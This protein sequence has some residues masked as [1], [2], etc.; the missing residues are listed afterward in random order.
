MTARVTSCRME[1]ANVGTLKL[2]LSSLIFCSRQPFLKITLSSRARLSGLSLALDTLFSAPSRP[3]M[4]YS[5]PQERTQP[6]SSSSSSAVSISLSPS[7]MT[8][9]LITSASSNIS[10]TQPSAHHTAA[11]TR[12]ARGLI[13]KMAAG[14]RGI[15][16]APQT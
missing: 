2:Y 10:L 1:M 12:T 3:L 15:F 11:A 4:S 6:L 8:R 13:F 9:L 7:C 5:K 16:L 14:F